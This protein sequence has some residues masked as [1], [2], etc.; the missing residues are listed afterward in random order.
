MSPYH[1]MQIKF[2]SI[3]P[4]SLDSPLYFSDLLS[5]NIVG[6]IKLDNIDDSDMHTANCNLKTILLHYCF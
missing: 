2:K 5:C 4:S 3:S 6:R 1:F